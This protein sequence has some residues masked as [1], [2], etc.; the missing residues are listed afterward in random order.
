MDPALV[1]V[2]TAWFA[3]AFV[4]GLCALGTAMVAV[5]VIALFLP[6]KTDILIACIQAPALSGLLFLLN[7]RHCR[8][9]SLIPMVAGIVPGAVAGLWTIQAVPGVWLELAIGI[10]LAFFLCWQ[11]FGRTVPGRESWALG[12]GAGAL[13]GFL[14]T[15]IS[16]EGPPVGAYGLYAGWPPREFLGTLGAFY[17]AR[18]AA[19]FALQ[20]K[21]GLY[22]PEV[23]HYGLWALPFSLAGTLLAF[24]VVRAIRIGAF[25]II[26]KC[27]IL[28]G[29]A[30][31]LGRSLAGILGFGQR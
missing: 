16:F 23:L 10:L 25:R 22:T 8:W 29:A 7:W 27:V 24:P 30:G 12:I 19:G 9:K 14:G 20:W 2:C 18:A 11:Q 21:A 17:F 3:G 6:V 15:S 13:S 4:G 26:L 1:A 28:A 5:P 31:C